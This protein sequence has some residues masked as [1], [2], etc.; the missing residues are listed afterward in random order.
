[1]L[2]QQFDRFD[3]TLCTDRTAYSFRQVVVRVHDAI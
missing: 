3:L 1:V 2:S